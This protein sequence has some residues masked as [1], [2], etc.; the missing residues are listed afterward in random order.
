MGKSAGEQAGKLRETL[1]ALDGL[2]WRDDTAISCINSVFR[3]LNEICLSEIEYYE[4]RRGKHRSL[5][6][7]A[8]GLGWFFGTSGLM[9]PLLAAASDLKV[10]GWGYFAFGL[11]GACFAA[12]NL[13]GFSRGHIRYVTTQISLE[14]AMSEVAIQ[15]KRLQGQNRIR[16]GNEEYE[17]AFDL[18]EGYCRIIYDLTLGETKEWSLA[19]LKSIDDYRI[20]IERNRGGGSGTA[21]GGAQ[22]DAAP[23]AKPNASPERQA[24]RTS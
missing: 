24:A 12:D 17:K 23:E 13:F 10:L 6:Q 2:Q 15:W 5:A 8:K 3:T 4:R 20:E 21:A 18:L 9:F 1:E 22:R 11:A 14:R 19:L 16:I 7:W